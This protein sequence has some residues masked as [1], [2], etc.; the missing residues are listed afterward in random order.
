MGSLEADCAVR[1]KRLRLRMRELKLDALLTLDSATMRWL[2]GWTEIFDDEQSHGALVTPSRLYIHTDTRYSEAMKANN[3]GGL[4]QISVDPAGR[5]SFVQSV[6]ARSKKQSLCLGYETTIRLDHYKALKKALSK[7]PVK[8]VETKGLFG[9]LRALKDAGEVRLLRKAQSITDAAFGELLTWVKPGLSELEIANRLEFALREK[10]AH[11]RAFPSIVASGSHSALPHARPTKRC[12]KRGD[13]LTLDFGARY[14]DY[15]SDMTRTLVI[16][17]A[18][19]KQRMMY[20][21]V[22]AAQARTK[23]GIKAG[24][25]GRQAHELALEVL[26]KA[27]LEKAFTHSLGHGVGIEVHELPS[28]SPKSTDPLVAGNVVTI[29]PGVYLPG[30]GGVRI[31][32]FGLV[33]DA[34]FSCFTRSPRELIEVR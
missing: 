33:T 26:K 11:G 14:H 10:G 2:S 34:G 25:T 17:E 18:S 22:L 3:S 8:L 21:A 23:A 30:Y 27:D 20:E 24:I 5:F 29:E 16:G 19:C 9:E 15:C 12:L 1:A 13:F 4:W 32:D 6:L 7:T 28:L 31:E